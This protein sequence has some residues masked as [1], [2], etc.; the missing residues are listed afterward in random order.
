MAD[1][2]TIISAELSDDERSLLATMMARLA[3]ADG[4]ID[5]FE[6]EFLNLFLGR[7]L[8]SDIAQAAKSLPDIPLSEVT[9]RGSANGQAIYTLCS[10]L[11]CVD[12]HVDDE[13]RKLLTD[14]AQALGLSQSERETL[15][16]V[17]RRQILFQSAEAMVNLP[18]YPPEKGTALAAIAGRLGATEQ[19]RDEVIDRF[20]FR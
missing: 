8:G 5:P 15:D 4:R 6:T 16:T 20:G 17:A 14:Y 2:E 9:R 1:F 7:A 19:E 10:L 13:E 11:T 12:E 18:G 3:C